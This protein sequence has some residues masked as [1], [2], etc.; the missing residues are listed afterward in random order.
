MTFNHS[1]LILFFV[2]THFLIC[3][4]CLPFAVSPHSPQTLLSS[5]L[6][7]SV[8]FFSMPKLLTSAFF[9]YLCLSQFLASNAYCGASFSSTCTLSSYCSMIWRADDLTLIL[10]YISLSFIVF[11]ALFVALSCLSWRLS[12]CLCPSG[13]VC[14]CFCWYQICEFYILTENSV[15]L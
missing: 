7:S 3:L 8:F 5:C 10:V 6:Y 1:Y 2:F 11:S 9:A 14:V 13:Y 4:R 15:T 12:Q